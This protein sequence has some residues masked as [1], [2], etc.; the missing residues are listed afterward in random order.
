MLLAPC[1]LAS[2]N[3]SVANYLGL[4]HEQPVYRLVDL[5]TCSS[6]LFLQSMSSQTGMAVFTAYTVGLMRHVG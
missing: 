2:T 3:D 4:T 5:A 6:F 1:I